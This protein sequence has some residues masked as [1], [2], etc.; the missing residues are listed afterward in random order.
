MPREKAKPPQEQQDRQTHWGS[1]AAWYDQLVGEAGSEYHRQVVLP[2][3]LRLLGAQP[4]QHVLD[5]ACGQGVLAR[6]LAARGAR[7]TAVDAS[8]ELI[9]LARQRDGQLQTPEPHRMIDY[10]V[11]DARDLGLLPESYF[12][13]AACVLAI[14]NI[15]P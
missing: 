7:V 1:V 5:V 2:G 13:S 6:L 10:R 4:D 14:Q 8:A 11:G 12:D 9:Q 15:H 3:V